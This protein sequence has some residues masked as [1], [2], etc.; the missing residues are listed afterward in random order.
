MNIYCLCSGI[1]LILTPLGQENIPNR[2]VLISGLKMYTIL[3]IGRAQ[4]VLNRRVSLFHISGVS[5]FQGCPHFIF[6]GPY[7]WGG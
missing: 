7:L 4:A 2:G 5:L 6:Q 3:M 1:S